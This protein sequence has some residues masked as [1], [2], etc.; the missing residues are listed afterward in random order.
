MSVVR[1]SKHTFIV[2]FILII[3]GFVILLLIY[4]IDLSKQYEEK[5]L[6]FELTKRKENNLECGDD[7]DYDNEKSIDPFKHI[8]SAY[9]YFMPNITNMEMSSSEYIGIEK[10]LKRNV[11]INEIDNEF[12]CNYSGRIFSIGIPK[13]G[14]STISILLQI[15]GYKCINNSCNHRVL[16]SLY[17]KPLKKMSEYL[18]WSTAPFYVDDISF[19]FINNKIYK[20]L[21]KLTQISQIFADQPWSYLYKLFD[22]W[23]P[24]KNKYIYTI[25]KSTYN[26]IN[27]LL[28]HTLLIEFR[29]MTRRLKLNQTETIKFA[30]NN[31]IYWNSKMENDLIKNN[32]LIEWIM[33]N[34]RLYEK[35]H[36]NVLKYF[37]S[38]RIGINKDKD[39]LILCLECETE[40]DLW[41]K[42]TKF[43][44]CNKTP[45]ISFPHE[46]KSEIN[47]IINE[48]YYLPQNFSLNWRNYNFSNNTQ[49][50]FNFFYN[51]QFNPKQRIY[52]FARE[53]LHFDIDHQMPFK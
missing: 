21:Y 22:E 15:L 4:S 12:Y 29:R 20:K 24:N 51:K 43:L 9:N 47:E 28:K 23:Y 19:S 8:S 6:S 14:T 53:F 52:N 5:L 39:L 27:S 49:S 25:R 35:H 10:K 44:Q 45:N 46:L 50:I 31:P 17:H 1:Y 33:Y 30:K 2:S 36:D 34:A 7:N 13:T 32:L 41:C 38:K 42:I 37:T 48:K 16:R 18:F 11:K 26:R 40:K 3:I